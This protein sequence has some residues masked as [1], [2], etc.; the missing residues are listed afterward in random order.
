M[1]LQDPYEDLF[2]D[3][4]DD[5]ARMRVLNQLSAIFNEMELAAIDQQATKLRV[6]DHKKIAK[7]LAGIVLKDSYARDVRLIAYLVLY[8]V[9]GRSES[10][11]PHIN[12]LRMP[13]DLDIAFLHECVKT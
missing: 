7:F 2:M 8:Q 13:E 12:R 5:E 11:L 6:V 10:T 4:Q 1:N 9:C 3:A